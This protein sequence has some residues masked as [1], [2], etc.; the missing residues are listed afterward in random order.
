MREY[1]VERNLSSVRHVTEDL[2]QDQTWPNI[3]KFTAERNNLHV[4]YLKK[5]FAHKKSKNWHIKSIHSNIRLFQ[6]YLCPKSLSTKSR[7]SLYIN[8]HSGEKP[9]FCEICQK[10]FVDKGSLAIHEKEHTGEKP[11]HCEICKISFAVKS[12]LINHK[13]LHSG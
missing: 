10:T 12:R 13:K 4:K 3:H 8:I 9:F 6:C 11:F 1:T 5:T 2:I 7:L